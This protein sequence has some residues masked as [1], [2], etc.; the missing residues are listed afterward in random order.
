MFIPFRLTHPH[1]KCQHLCFAQSDCEYF[2][3]ICVRRMVV[4][5]AQTEYF[6]CSDFSASAQK[7]RGCSSEILKRTPR[8][9]VK[10]R[11]KSSSRQ[12]G[13]SFCSFVATTVLFDF[14]R[15]YVVSGYRFDIVMSFRPFICLMACRHVIVPVRHVIFI[16]ASRINRAD[17]GTIMTTL[18][19]A[20]MERG[21]TLRTN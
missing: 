20:A 9:E 15:R 2:G 14:K 7:G 8:Y 3:N 17:L 19:M 16:L 12:C 1:T 10:P 13:I 5:F 18:N 4:C 21:T 11:T 6:S